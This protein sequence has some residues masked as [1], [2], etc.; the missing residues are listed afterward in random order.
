MTSG[1]YR[2]MCLDTWLPVSGDVEEVTKLSGNKN[3]AGGNRLLGVGVA[4][5]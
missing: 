4:H 2:L 1:P 3:P 5:L